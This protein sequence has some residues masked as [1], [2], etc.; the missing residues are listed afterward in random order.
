MQLA[1]EQA[2]VWFVSFP[3][4]ATLRHEAPTHDTAAPLLLSK[5]SLLPNSSAPTW[6]FQSF[7]RIQ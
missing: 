5:P 3:D 4:I 7:I 1:E 2:E 6:M